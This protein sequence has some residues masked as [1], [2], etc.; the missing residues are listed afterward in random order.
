MIKILLISSCENP[1]R[2]MRSLLGGEEYLEVVGEAMNGK[3]GLVLIEKLLP[4]I[5]ISDLG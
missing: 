2:A 3:E 4:D 1:R 5:I